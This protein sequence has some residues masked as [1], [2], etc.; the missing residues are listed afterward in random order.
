V[1]AQRSRRQVSQAQLAAELGI[2]GSYLSL[3]ES[4][5]RAATPD[6]LQRLAT[7]LGCSADYLRAGRG[8]RHD[9]DV[10][11]ELRF[12]EVALRAGDAEA[13]LERFKKVTAAASARGLSDA[14]AEAHWGLARAQ[15]AVG[16]LESAIE[17]YE[18]LIRGEE[19]PGSLQR[20]VILTALCRAYRECGDLSR[21]IEVGESALA[22]YTGSDEQAALSDT[23]IALASTLVGCYYERG[24]L[25]R[26]HLLAQETL[27]RA[28]ENGSAVARAAAL[29]NAGLISEARGDLRTASTYVERALALY[30]ETDNAR[31]TALLRVAAAWM[32]LRSDQPDLAEAEEYVARAL[33]DLPV[34]GSVLDVAYAQTELARCHLL[35]GDQQAALSLAEDVVSRLAKDGPRLET[36]RARLLA[37]DAHIVEGDPDAAAACYEQ[38]AVDLRSSGADRQAAAAWRELA[39]SLASLGRH[40]EA[41]DA[42]RAASDAVGVARPPYLPQ[43]LRRNSPAAQAAER[44]ASDRPRRQPSRS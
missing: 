29:W 26:G 41:V 16:S 2:S 32:M 30:S 18:G 10:D 37:G 4:G 28:D 43:R 5:R 25:T 23:V 31:A 22:A 1:R 13:A 9:D 24:D 44:S 38:A 21:A 42:Y 36:A 8:G 15:E 11:L 40:E 17:A 33:R 3:I 7:A 27:A 12:A 20:S 34:V 19:L 39:E 14:Q 6:L 35:R